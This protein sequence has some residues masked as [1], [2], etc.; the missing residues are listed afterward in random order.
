VPGFLLTDA[1]S[2][3]TTGWRVVWI[4]W[5]C[6]FDFNWADPGLPEVLIVLFNLGNFLA[7]VAFAVRG[8]VTLRMLT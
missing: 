8:P 1:L 3:R 2:N 7:V 4:R 5:E 6:Q